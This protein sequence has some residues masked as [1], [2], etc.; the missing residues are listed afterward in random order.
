[1][2]DD[3]TNKS[4]RLNLVQGNL[5]RGEGA[6]RES[7]TQRQQ[8]ARYNNAAVTLQRVLRGRL[9]RKKLALDLKVYSLFKKV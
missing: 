1:M 9:A 2:L 5:K 3:V 4:Y 8:F 6:G 7:R